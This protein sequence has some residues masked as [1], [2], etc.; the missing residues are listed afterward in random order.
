L[1]SDDGVLVLGAG[2]FVRA[3]ELP[4]FERN[5]PETLAVG[6]RLCDVAQRAAAPRA[7]MAPTVTTAA[8]DWPELLP[9]AGRFL[10][11]VDFLGAIC[12]RLYTGQHSDALN[13]AEYF[14]SACIQ[15]TA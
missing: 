2:G 12:L 6:L 7:T 14:E 15:A 11:E 10:R 13:Q 3:T 5:R 9:R 4:L 8:A 1:R